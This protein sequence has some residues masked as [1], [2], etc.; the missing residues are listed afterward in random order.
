MPRSSDAGVCPCPNV[1]PGEHPTSPAGIHAW[2]GAG[3]CQ[4]RARQG[5]GGILGSMHWTTHPRE[6]CVRRGTS[7]A[8]GSWGLVGLVVAAIGVGPGQS[9]GTCTPADCAA[10]YEHPIHSQEVHDVIQYFFHSTAISVERGP[11]HS[12]GA[13][14][15]HN[16]PCSLDRICTASTFTNTQTFESCWS[17]STTTSITTTMTGG[18]VS[19]AGSRAG[20]SLGQGTSHTTQTSGCVTTASASAL[21]GDVSDCFKTHVREKW[22]EKKVT[23]RI[24]FRGGVRLCYVNFGD[25]RGWVHDYTSFCDEQTSVVSLRGSGDRGV[26]RAPLPKKCGGAVPANPDPFDGM[27]MEQCCSPLSPCDE[28]PQGQISCCPCTASP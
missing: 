20:I 8:L 26:Q 7:S 23:G 13:C 24:V 11:W 21:V 18:W 28:V 2:T 3:A 25:G 16:G 27:T 4:H 1:V 6:D 12:E 15:C 9:P 22:V 5:R 17:A 14:N 19:R 10:V